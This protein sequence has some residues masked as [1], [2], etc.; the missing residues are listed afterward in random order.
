MKMKKRIVWL[1]S[2]V[3]AI[4]FLSCTK[5][6]DTTIVPV[7]PETYI[8]DILQVIPDSTKHVFDSVFGIMPQGLVPPNIEGE[9]VISPKQ[10]VASSIP[11]WPLNPADPELDVPFGF[12]D[13]LNGIVKVNLIE[14]QEQTTDTAFVKGAGNAFMTYFIENKSYNVE[15]SDA[16]YHVKMKRGVVMKGYVGEDGIR[17]LYLAVVILSVEDDSNGVIPEYAPGTYFIYKDGNG[18]ATRQ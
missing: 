6:D 5:N 14:G 7:G 3:L 13:Q 2:L 18:M 1:S 10:R 16:T 17:D 11:N 12:Y 9:Y 8:T 15:T 4:S